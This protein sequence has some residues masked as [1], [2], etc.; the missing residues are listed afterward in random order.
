MNK[1]VNRESVWCGL[2][3]GRREATAGW[4]NLLGLCPP[5]E[6]KVQASRHLL[7]ESDRHLLNGFANI[8]IG[9]L[10]ICASGYRHRVRKQWQP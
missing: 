5:D 4:I 10:H 8:S 2:S 1:T 7:Q 3:T 9:K 6:D